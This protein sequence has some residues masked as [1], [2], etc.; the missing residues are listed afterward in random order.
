[1]NGQNVAV[2]QMISVKFSLYFSTHAVQQ[3]ELYFIYAWVTWN[4]TATY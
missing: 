4:D 1:M 3:L 2:D